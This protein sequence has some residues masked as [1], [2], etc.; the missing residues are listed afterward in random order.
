MVLF[1][2]FSLDCLENRTRHCEGCE[3]DNEVVE[4]WNPEFV[5]NRRNRCRV[6]V[7][8]DAVPQLLGGPC[9]KEFSLLVK[10][11]NAA[12]LGYPFDG[13]LGQTESGG[14]LGHFE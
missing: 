14:E 6:T 8:F 1:D 3:L 5:G 11:I 9:I 10:E 12:L 7:Q 4:V 13:I 2:K